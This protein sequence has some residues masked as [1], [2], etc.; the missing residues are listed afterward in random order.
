MTVR[1]N[2]KTGLSAK[3]YILSYT[4]V[5][6]QVMQD[7]ARYQTICADN[8]YP[9]DS[10]QPLDIDHFAETVFEVEIEHT[11]IPQ[12]KNEE[13]LGYYD[14]INRKIVCDP[15]VCNSDG[16]IAFTVAHET[17]HISLHSCLAV[18]A[19]VKKWQ[20]LHKHAHIEW[21]ANAYAS[22]LI[23]P[24]GSVE[25]LLRDENYLKFRQITDPVNMRDFASKMRERFG[26]SQHAAEIRLERMGVPMINKKYS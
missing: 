3:T 8:G 11:S 9:V 26:M 6:N 23:A 22:F 17:G 10:N 14:P 19:D 12:N 16:R 1:L 4:D 15:E 25:D 7:R 5:E 20:G 24:T 2:P 13:V 21:Q 18:G